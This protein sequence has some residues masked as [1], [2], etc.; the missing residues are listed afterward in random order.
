MDELE[1]ARK[2]AEI[3]GR[4]LRK[5]F[6]KP[7]V[8]S[9]GYRDVVTDADLECERALKA[10]FEKNFPAYGFLGEETARNFVEGKNWVVD[11]LDGTREFSYG[12]PYFSV[13]IALLEGKQAKV[14]VVH[15][16]VTRDLFTAVAGKGAF[17]NGERIHCAGKPRLSDALSAGCFI[18]ERKELV[19]FAY[20]NKIFLL[21]Y[22]PALDLCGVA[23]GR[24]DSV[25]Y[26]SST[27]DDHAA[28]A[29]MVQESGGVVSNFGSCKYDPFELG[30]MAGNPSLHKE[31][32]K[33][34]PRQFDEFK[35]EEAQY[36]T[37]TF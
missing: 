29:L 8:Y 11:P 26:T 13:S 9:K 14:G 7:N 5:H 23:R 34:F 25:V 17:H 10:F 6:G 28:G 35:S 3:G 30:I 20:K 2:A 19:E 32:C 33:V 18:Y 22:S 27:Y 12:I 37:T 15:N 4:I 24:I 36:T 1:A 21:N 16:P 31:L